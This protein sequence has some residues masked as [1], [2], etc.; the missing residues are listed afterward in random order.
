METKRDQNGPILKKNWG[1]STV[2]DE[3]IV[4]GCESGKMMSKLDF[5]LLMFLPSQQTQCTL[6]I[7]IE[8]RGDKIK[9][10]T[11]GEVLKY[12]GI[13]IILSKFEF[14]KRRDLWS[15]IS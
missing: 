11:T 9:E 5:F 6:L 13:L 15:N 12:F 4:K 1:L 8:L 3:I 14:N 2:T 7:N 10:T